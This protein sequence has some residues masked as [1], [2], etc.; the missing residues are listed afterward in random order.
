MMSQ[1]IVFLKTDRHVIEYFMNKI[2]ASVDK[3]EKNM[4]E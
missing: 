1:L 3:T 2:T 4:K